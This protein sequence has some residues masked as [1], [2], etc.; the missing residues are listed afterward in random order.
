VK[1]IRP[2]S[3]SSLPRF[4]RG[5]A[6]GD[7]VFFAADDGEHGRELWMTDGTPEGT[8]LVRDIRRDNSAIWDSGYSSLTALEG[9]TFFAADDGVHGLH[10]WVSDG[11]EGGTSLLMDI[12]EAALPTTSSYPSHFTAWGDRLVFAAHGELWATDGTAEG[13]LPL[14]VLLGQA[15]LWRTA[16]TR[17]VVHGVG[18]RP[19][20][21][22][23]WPA[24]PVVEVN[25]H[26]VFGADDGEL[27]W[28]LWGSDGT[29][30]GTSLLRDIRPG[31]EGFSTGSWGGSEVVGDRLFFVVEDQE[32]SVS[33]LWT[34]DGTPE[35]T[36]PFRELI[37]QPAGWIPDLPV[38]DGAGRLLLVAND[39][40]H[41]RELW[42]SD[43]TPEG[44]F[45]VKDVRPGAE[46]SGISWCKQWQDGEWAIMGLGTRLFFTADD[47]EHGRELWVTDGTGRG[48]YLLGDLHPGPEGAKLHLENSKIVQ[49]LLFFEADGSDDGREIWTSDGTPKGTCPFRERIGRPAELEGSRS[50]MGAVGR[51][52]FQGRELPYTWEPW[53]SD[54][55]PDG[56]LPLR[57]LAAQ[58]PL[59]APLFRTFKEVSGRLFF[60]ATRHDGSDM[61]LWVSDG[62]SAGTHLLR[63]YPDAFGPTSHRIREAGG[64]AV[65]LACDD[66]HGRELW[67]SDGTPEGTRLV[68][69]TVPGPASGY[70][71]HDHWS[72]GGHLFFSA[73]AEREA[74]RLWT[75]DGTPEG[76]C[77]LEGADSGSGLCFAEKYFS[78]WGEPAGGYY[79]ES[80][81]VGATLFFSAD[82]GRHGFELWALPGG[83]VSSFRRGDTDGDGET[84]MADARQ[85]L[86][87]LLFG[88][89]RLDC[90]AAANVN[91]DGRVDLADPIFL[92]NFLFRD[93]PPPGPPFP[94]CG[95][96]SLYADEEAGCEMPPADCR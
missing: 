77:R 40:Q 83:A 74:A 62:T 28:E 66:E 47:G 32:S 5:A 88:G 16:E 11:T 41:G 92:L 84:S 34:T 61:E 71:S 67:A 4:G 10:L 53:V 7:R 90:V 73:G 9:R 39:G 44:T 15:P 2:G 17:T 14:R 20:E 37:G 49:G 35:G 33:E 24:L 30:E 54:G 60:L 82:D 45:L 18:F 1:D 57:E 38:V 3:E 46:S 29:A 6:R 59:W 19:E 21:V 96:S 42:R 95:F 26:I 94:E 70:F 69:D 31:P 58:S 64:R 79:P 48:T 8:R 12:R 78:S 75:T 81:R 86:E 22:L 65:F 68:A 36:L 56:T 25:G 89:S 51:L 76:T 55:T 63:A 13:T 80:M 72:D 50:V 52:F 87:W 23:S 27:G 93:G 43:S 85:V 91:E